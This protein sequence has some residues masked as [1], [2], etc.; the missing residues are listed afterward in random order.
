[1]TSKIFS[2]VWSDALTAADRDAFVSDWALSSIWE[3][4]PDGDT[5]IDHAEL[6]GRVWDLAHMSVADIRH[7][8]GLTQAAFAERFCLPLRTLQN[9]EIR[10]G[11]APYIRMM[12]AR[13]CGLADGL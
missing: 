12:F 4:A 11:C 2:A 13:L 6:C 10:G 3:D 9:W 8:A 7:A 5:I 1:M